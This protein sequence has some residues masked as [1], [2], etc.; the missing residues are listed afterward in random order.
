MV[1]SSILASLSWTLCIHYGKGNQGNTARFVERRGRRQHT[2]WTPSLAIMS[3][4]GWFGEE[5]AGNASH[6]IHNHALNQPDGSAAITYDELDCLVRTRSKLWIPSIL[7]ACEIR[8][9]VFVSFCAS[10]QS[11]SGR[12]SEEGTID[13]KQQILEARRGGYIS[14]AQAG[15]HNHLVSWRSRRP[16]WI[17]QQSI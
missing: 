14:V 10:H 4:S 17:K 1:D 7:V 12:V 13:T 8:S 15:R 2:H 16:K 5:E 6:V 11:S 9:E 3:A